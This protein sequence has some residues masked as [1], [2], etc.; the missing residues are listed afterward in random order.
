[1]AG[2]DVTGIHTGHSTHVLIAGDRAVHYMA[3]MDLTRV[4]THHGTHHI[5]RV[6]G[7]HVAVDNVKVIDLATVDTEET[8]GVGSCI[9][10]VTHCAATT[11]EVSQEG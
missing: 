9:G 4:V 11:V 8:T 10:K 5:M 2:C 3:V 7:S 1:M 6:G